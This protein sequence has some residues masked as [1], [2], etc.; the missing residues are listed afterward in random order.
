MT[1]VQPTAAPAP[2]P[3][4]VK[5]A[6]T[7]VN[8]HIQPGLSSILARPPLVGGVDYAGHTSLPPAAGPP[9]AGGLQP[10]N[11]QLV[12]PSVAAQQHA[13]E[14]SAKLQTLEA[15]QKENE[16][17]AKA[18]QDQL[19]ASE[20]ANEMAYRAGV[21]SLGARIKRAASTSPGLLTDFE[22]N[23]LGSSVARPTLHTPVFGDGPLA[24]LY[25]SFRPFLLRGILGQVHHSGPLAS[26]RNRPWTPMAMRMSGGAQYQ[27]NPLSQIFG[28]HAHQLGS[29]LGGHIG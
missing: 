7:V 18:V 26:M 6:P 2:P 12:S 16:A 10:V 14:E 23:P 4:P 28:Q 5:G 9:L 21:K 29:M 11:G 15:Q 27:P 3:N 19:R 8:Q 1:N 17:N 22:R 24:K 20:K 25:Q 13:T